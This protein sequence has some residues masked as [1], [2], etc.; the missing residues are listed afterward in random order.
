MCCMANSHPESLCA[1]IIIYGYTPALAL[2]VIGALYFGVLAIAALAVVGHFRYSPQ[3]TCN[4]QLAYAVS[5]SA[6][7]FITLDM[8]LCV[9]SS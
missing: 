7:C 3:L 9:V 5:Q 8:M 6:R 1:A 2:G 4:T